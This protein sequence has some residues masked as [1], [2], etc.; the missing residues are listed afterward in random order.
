MGSVL[1]TYCSR[2]KRRD[3]RL[4]P[5]WERY[6]S[7]RVR[8]VFKRAEGAGARCLILSGEYGLIDAERPI[9]W[10]DRLLRPEDVEARVDAVAQQLRDHHVE[11]V[12]YH[13]VPPDIVEEVRP[14]RDLL[15]R[16]CLQV[17][18]PLELAE[19]TGVVD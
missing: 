8:S 17:G 12:E 4:L 3:E 10:Y 18:V 7:E 6:L 16:A 19:W 2:E 14:Y 15:E 5:A 13:T 9:P 11:A 1:V